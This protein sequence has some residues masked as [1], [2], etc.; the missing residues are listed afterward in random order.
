MSDFDGQLIAGEEVVARTTK[1]W[2]APVADS[3]WAFV[4]I[5][6]VIILAWLQGD[7]TDGIMGFLNR[8]MGLV[9]LALVLGSVATIGYAIVAWRTA[10]YGVTN[11]RVIGHDGL[12]RRRN[13][14][15]LLSSISDVK[16]LVPA[17]GRALGY[18]NLKIMSASGE[19]GA[20]TLTAMRD[21]EAFK[22]AIIEQKTG[23]AVTVQRQGTAQAIA[24]AQATHGTPAAAPPAAPTSA[25]VVAT[26]GELAK[27][28]DAGAISAADY[29]A[30]KVELLARI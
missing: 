30:K 20:D 6:G 16:S 28:R 24:A 1:H 26:L 9:E 3:K 11:Q 15:T 10:E 21:V 29:E 8:I 23:S 14:D 2:I 25:E 17:L 27:L 12:L 22:K 13:Y 5:I 7:Q 4:A 18:G 19:A